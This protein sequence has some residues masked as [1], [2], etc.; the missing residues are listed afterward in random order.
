MEMNELIEIIIVTD[1]KHMSERGTFYHAKQIAKAVMEGLE[2][3]AEVPCSVG[4]SDA[5]DNGAIAMATSCCGYIPQLSE[6]Y[7]VYWN[8]YNRV[9]Q[10]HNCGTVWKPEGR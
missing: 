3:V 2:P 8:P 5:P 4:L 6:T 7:P 10:C 1:D 9:V